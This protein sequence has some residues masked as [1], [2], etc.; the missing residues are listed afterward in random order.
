[1]PDTDKEFLSIV[2]PVYRESAHI[3]EVLAEVERALVEA[4]VRFELVLVDDG[5]PDD[6]WQALNEAAK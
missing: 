6:T 3:G 1:M 5:S 2:M 4:G